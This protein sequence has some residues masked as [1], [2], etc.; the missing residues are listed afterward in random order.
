MKYSTFRWFRG[1]LLRLCGAVGLVFGSWTTTAAQ[2]GEPAGRLANLSARAPTAPG[3]GALTAG[4]VIAGP[5]PKRVLVRAAGP[6]LA[7]FG[8]PGALREARLELYQGATLIAAN[9]GWDA[10]AAAS[11]VDQVARAVGAFP[12]DPGSADAALVLTL[13][14]GGYTARVV[15]AREGTAPGVALA[16]V[17]DAD[18][19]APA[20]LVNLSA[21][22]RSG[23]GAD[24]LFAGFVVAGEGRN[25]LLVRAA[26]PALAAFG[27][28][29]ALS[30]PQLEVFQGELTAGFNEDWEANTNAAQ[31]AAVAGGAGA[32]PFGRGAKDAALL[33]PATRGAYTAVVS[34]ATEEGGVALVEVYDTAS[35]RSDFGA[36]PFDLVGFARV[37]GHGLAALTGGGVPGRPYDPRTRT[38]NFWRIDG[39]TA[40]APDFPAQFQVAM[41]SD[42]PLVVELDT[43][44][45]LS[46]VALP[47]NGATAIAHPDLFTSG[48]TSGFVGL[49]GVGSNKTIYSAFG[50]GGFRRGTL[51]IDGTNNIILRNLK[52]RELWE[53]DDATAGQYDR[54]DWDYITV[55]S[56]FSGA[57]V[58]ARAHHIWIDHCDF[59]KSYDG[60]LDIV[61]GADLITVSWCK[62][63]GVMSGETARWVRRQM[64]FLEANQALFPNYRNFRSFAGAALLREREQFQ[65]KG[66][67]VGNS[68]EALTAGRDRGH[69]NV[70]FHHNWYARVDER[71]PRM[72]FGNAHV[73]NLLADSSGAAAVVALAGGG[74]IATSGA[75]VR[76][77]NSW[78]TGVRQPVSVVVGTE[79]PGRIMVRDSV[80]FD[81]AADRNVPFDPAHVVSGDAFVWNRPDSRTGIAGW[82]AADPGM[83]PAG[84]TPA[85]RSLADYM[86]SAEF[87]WM[88]RSWVGV[89][90]PADAAEAQLWRARWQSTGP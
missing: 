62:F 85:G 47:S 33:L 90:V 78:F 70:T 8:L 40:A 75:A 24:A 10:G 56:R 29:E 87:M 81:A 88:N 38:G 20:R 54:N 41:A 66:N 61:Q 4:F 77:E 46:R 31:L 73:F 74:I 67:L 34:A 84:Y 21:R 17:Y 35:V 18:P 60:L 16:E 68:T 11:L 76:V 2:I 12:F 9:S 25:R 63:A 52:F 14:P 15:P 55:L 39:A 43:M 44:L 19:Q 42:Q 65:F 86:D 71:M 80:N 3:D 37:P 7:G 72:R 1:G 53:W 13:E 51:R 48:G 5:G 49:L 45:D 79:P 64:D 26:G 82:P 58:T 50:A 32:F 28:P 36:R 23:A 69:L 83:M 59:E 6:S 30:D 89:L 57:D 22:A 27:L